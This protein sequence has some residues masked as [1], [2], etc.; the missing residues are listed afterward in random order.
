MKKRNYLLCVLL[1]IITL[2]LYGLYWLVQ[3]TDTVNELAKPYK[4]TSGVKALLFGL[5]TCGIYTY[6]WSWK[7]G[8]VLDHERSKAGLSPKNLKL[9]FLILTFFAWPASM[10]LMQK[11]INEIGGVPEQNASLYDMQQN[12]GNR[13]MRW[14]VSIAGTFA[15]LLFLL[16]SY[17]LKLGFI[18]SN[19]I[20]KGWGYDFI[21]WMNDTLTLTY[22]TFSFSLILAGICIPVISCLFLGP[23]YGGGKSKA[24]RIVTMA[25]MILLS[26]SLLINGVFY[27]Q[28]YVVFRV[29]SSLFVCNLVMVSSMLVAG[30]GAAVFCSIEFMISVSVNKL[31]SIFLAAT[32][33]FFGVTSVGIAVMALLQHKIYVVPGYLFLFGLPFL[34]LAISQLSGCIKRNL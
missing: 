15:V 11:E 2:G 3:I 18:L 20:G 23:C 31:R 16:V 6:F 22:N 17:I 27:K 9:L 14:F 34:L 12:T 10:A 4:K 30:I 33:V 25:A 7:I 13:T 8:V 19:G 24:V 1:T 26:V 21:L 32:T 5:V 28:F 29:L